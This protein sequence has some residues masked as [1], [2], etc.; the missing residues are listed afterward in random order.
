MPIPSRPAPTLS[1]PRIQDLQRQIQTLLAGISDV[2]RLEAELLLMQVLQVD[3]GFLLRESD[4]AAAPTIIARLEEMIAERLGGRPLAYLLGHWAFWNLELAVSPAVLIPRPDTE[5]L[6]ESALERLPP[7]FKGNILDLGTGSGAIALALARERPQARVFAVERSARALAVAQNNGQALG[8]SVRWLQGDWFAPLATDLRF[9]LIVSNP[10][11]IAADD[12][13]LNALQ[14]EP[15]EALISG[16]DG[17]D[18]L[19]HIIRTAPGHLE[20][21]GHLL[22]EHGFEQGQAVRDLLTNTGY[23]QVQTRLDLG[24]R[25]RVSGGQVPPQ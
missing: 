7:T 20:P 4:Q 19:R 3:R 10:P 14:D 5:I 12:P 24:G 21:G 11:Y 9:D 25:E 1:G 2:P 23:Q 22:L 8:L 18:A 17:L 16:P 6:V 13:H 15:L